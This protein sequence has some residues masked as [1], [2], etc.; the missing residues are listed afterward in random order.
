[1]AMASGRAALEQQQRARVQ[2]Q[3]RARV[4]Q[5]RRVEQQALERQPAWARTGN[6]ARVR[7]LLMRVAR[8]WFRGWTAYVTS[9][10]G[11]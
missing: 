2:Q 9:I 6:T 8:A 7:G 11:M 4:Q 5:E 3:R 1:M 10:R